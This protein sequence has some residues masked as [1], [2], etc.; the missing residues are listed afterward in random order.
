M[1]KK[2]KY[3]VPPP[4]DGSTFKQLFKKLAAAGAGR[5]VGDDGF[6]SGPWTPDLLAA[7]ISEIEGNKSGIELRT[8]QLW[9][10]EN[11][12]GISAENIRWLARVFGC[13]DP[14][15]TA[16][17][18]VALSAG[19][20]AQ[21]QRRRQRREGPK[22]S[23]A[24]PADAAPD[25]PLNAVPVQVL[26]AISQDEDQAA[27]RGFRLARASEALFSRGSPLNL[28]A[29]VFAGAVA[30]GF[31]S[32]IIGVH[33]VS[34]DHN[35][36]NK[37]IGYLWA[38]NWTVLFMVFLPLFLGLVAETLLY[39][40]S[41]G[42]SR[43]IS[44]IAAE[45]TVKTWMQK[46]EASS[47]TFWSVFLICLVFAG[48]IQWAGVRLE[49]L[50]SGKNSYA[51]DWGSLALLRPDVVS[52]PVSIAFTGIA[53]LYMSLCFYAL[54]V[55][56]IL[57]YLIIDDFGK[58]TDTD[59]VKMGQILAADG[60]SLA[61]IIMICVFR[62]S[63]LVILIATAMKLQ[64]IYI[65]SDAE[66]ILIWMMADIRSFL[67]IETRTGSYIEVTMPNHFSSLI[68]LLATCFV[69]VYGI[70]GLRLKTT[71]TYLVAKMIIVMALLCLA[72]FLMGSFVGWAMLLGISSFVAV[73]ALFDPEFTLGRNRGFRGD[74][75]VP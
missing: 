42:R 56:L 58:L 31:L 13:D 16:D 20:A 10:Q 37:Q 52:V 5:P 40:K 30:L 73:C 35:G 59:K 3:F 70:V 29:S 36:I 24:L 46:I 23:D 19:L 33:N 38:P 62:C 32:F 4:S 57:L 47:F 65:S 68:V 2:G 11:E 72:Y 60:R 67:N 71:D 49:P 74:H 22:P 27:G 41:E 21:R 44:Q 64:S 12:R 61:R 15:A 1:I 28:P 54:F 39:W 18:Q 45:R 6:P 7:A 75:S 8:V 63:M 25:A 50:L 48:I 26:P 66:N 53:Y 9:F 69:F 55:G 51:I 34:Y 43:L 17:W 14:V